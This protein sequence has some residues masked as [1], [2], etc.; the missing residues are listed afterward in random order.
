VFVSIKHIV[1][2]LQYFFFRFHQKSKNYWEELIKNSN[3]KLNDYCKHWNLDFV[4][5]ETL[6][7][8]NT[9][10]VLKF[11]ECLKLHLRWKLTCSATCSSNPE[12]NENTGR[13]RRSE[14][15]HQEVRALIKISYQNCSPN[16]SV[17]YMNIINCIYTLHNWNPA[18][19]IKQILKC[20][21]CIFLIMIT[22]IQLM[23]L[24]CY[25]QYVL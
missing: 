3:G 22:V 11:N 5:S 14:Q 15:I 6:F 18:E 1:L 16:H 17:C 21:K 20:C 19:G 24:T 10:Q 8:A 25:N 13:H 7:S 2:I 9:L 12:G 23:S 4:W